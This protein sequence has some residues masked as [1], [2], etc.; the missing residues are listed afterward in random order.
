MG[1]P[2]WDR[3]APPANDEKKKRK[4]YAYKSLSYRR[5]EKKQDTVS[6]V[7]LGCDKKFEAA[8]KFNRLCDYCSSRI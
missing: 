3:P 8:G 7:C 4:K 1:G 2:R 6:R 5:E